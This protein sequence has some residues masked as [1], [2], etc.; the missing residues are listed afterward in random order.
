MLQCHSR[1]GRNG[2]LNFAIR[3]LCVSYVIFKHVAVLCFG[4]RKVLRVFHILPPES[5]SQ[6]FIDIGLSVFG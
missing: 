6:T 3:V 5:S 2:A 1:I 4:A